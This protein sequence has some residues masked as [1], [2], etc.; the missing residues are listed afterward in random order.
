MAKRYGVPMSTDAEDDHL[1]RY[2]GV[3]STDEIR[4]EL[5]NRMFFRLYQCANM[6][7]KKIGRAHV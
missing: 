1:I 2:S 6:L 3:E 5:A 7:H 4:Y